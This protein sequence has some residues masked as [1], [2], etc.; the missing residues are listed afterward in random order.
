MSHI[1]QE[2]LLCDN[3]AKILE[4]CLHDRDNIHVI[5]MCDP[6]ILLATNVSLCDN[7]SIIGDYCTSQPKHV[8]ARKQNKNSKKILAI[9]AY[10]TLSDDHTTWLIEL[11]VYLRSK[12][13]ISVEFSS[14]DWY[15]R[16]TFEIVMRCLTKDPGMAKLL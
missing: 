11:L 16:K 9:N 3:F 12:F 2:K 14:F 5:R 8:I 15:D 13:D 4:N 1:L 7:T 10:S 6:S